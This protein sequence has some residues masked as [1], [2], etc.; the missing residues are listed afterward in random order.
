[1]VSGR[2]LKKFALIV[3]YIFLWSETVGGLIRYIFG[4]LNIPFLIY[5]PKILL[6]VGMIGL[7]FLSLYRLKLGV[8]YVITV[9][10]MMFSLM[11]GIIYVRDMYQIYAF[12]LRDI[13]CRESW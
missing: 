8:T 12:F 6:F 11:V 2:F 1:M 10:F 7:L 4:L 5:I 3:G 13:N 9:S